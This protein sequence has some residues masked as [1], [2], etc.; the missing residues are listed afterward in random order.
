[1]KKIIILSSFAML[2]PLVTL[3]SC[4]SS[5]II[6][7]RIWVTKNEVTQEDINQSIDDY[8]QATNASAKVEI[9]NRLFSGVTIENF[10][11]FTTNVTTNSITLT[12][13]SGYAF[14][15]KPSI[16]ARVVPIIFY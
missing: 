4:S 9:L 2:V 7:L 16:K 14:G 1:M 15:T 10:P 6:D 11:Y 8:K 5:S 12:A 3:S 13:L